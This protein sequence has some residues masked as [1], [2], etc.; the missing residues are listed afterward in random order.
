[1]KDKSILKI[2]IIFYVL[3]A[4]FLCLLA[5]FT[6]P[7]SINSKHTMFPVIVVLAILFSILGGLLFFYTSKSKLRGALRKLILLTGASSAGFLVSIIL[8]NIFSGLLILIFGPYFWTQIGLVDEPLFFI[9]ALFICPL[10][11]SIGA[12]GTIIHLVRKMK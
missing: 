8:H 4:I 12:A 3:V 2:K 5:Y 10:G 7:G 6:I 9:I 1:M 11:F